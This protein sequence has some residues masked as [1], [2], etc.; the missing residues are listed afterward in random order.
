MLRKLCSFL[1]ACLVLASIPAFAQTVGQLEGLDSASLPAYIDSAMGANVG[2]NPAMVT[3]GFM[4]FLNNTTSVANTIG[5][6]S[7]GALG[8]NGSQTNHASY[9]GNY[10]T[11]TSSGSSGS[12]AGIYAESMN[13]GFTVQQPAYLVAGVITGPNSSDI[14]SGSSGVRFYVGVEADAGLQDVNTISSATAN[15]RSFYA[16]GYD[17]AIDAN[18]DWYAVSCQNGCSTGAW[19]RVDTGV[20]LTTSTYYNLGIDWRQQGTGSGGT[21]YYYLGGKQVAAITTNLVPGSMCGNIGTTTSWM[22][23]DS[24]CTLSSTAVNWG[25]RYF[26]INRH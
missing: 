25:V 17:G 8:T 12:L 10:T 4:P 26:L 23:L 14:A 22:W 3:A 2:A 16:L 7:G 5:I 9:L 1:V 6:T 11:Y 18:H 15:G 24:I 13:G 21:V 20:P 19:T